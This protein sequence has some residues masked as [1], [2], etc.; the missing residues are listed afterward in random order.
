[1]VLHEGG[2]YQDMISAGVDG[3]APASTPV[4]PA[5]PLDTDVS[6][7]PSW[8]HRHPFLATTIGIGS[9]LGLGG[10][11]VLQRFDVNPAGT[12]GAWGGA[13]GFFAGTIRNTNPNRITAEDITRL[14]SSQESH[15][16]IP[17]YKPSVDG[18]PAGTDAVADILAQLVQNTPV[19]VGGASPTT[20]GSYSFIP[21]GLVS[22]ET[23]TKKRSA[24]QEKLYDYGNR[25]GTYIKGY[26]DTHYGTTQILKDQLEDRTNPDKISAV[27]RLGLD[28]QALGVELR[29]IPD[30][31]TEAAGMHKEYANAYIR[32]GLDLVKVMEAEGDEAFV[33][34]ITTYNADVEKLTTQFLL[35]VA[36]FGTNEVTFSSSDYGNIFMFSPDLSLLQ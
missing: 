34:A 33:N 22:V 32:A 3:A 27:K 2:N 12:S 36:L 28:M 14:Q 23:P 11:M 15:A 25:V 13:G 16:V 8:V 5:P 9:L 31:P 24:V 17:I 10:V 18:T 29:N 35:L 30:I 4:T 7:K 19:S 1:M 6:S 21:Q 26:E 20:P